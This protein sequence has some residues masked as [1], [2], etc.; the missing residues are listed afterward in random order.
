M[1]HIT[2]SDGQ[3][4]IVCIE[5]GRSNCQAQE[6]KENSTN[7]QHAGH[8]EN[9]IYALAVAF[10]SSAAVTAG[11]TFLPSFHRTRGGGA[12]LRRPSRERTRTTR[13]GRKVQVAIRNMILWLTSPQ[14]ESSRCEW[15]AQDTQYAILMYNLGRTYS[16]GRKSQGEKKLR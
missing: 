15:I 9:S 8:S 10:A 12:R 5:A 6:K 11:L 13:N 2:L 7:A 16:V 14:D 4:Q 3:G 1:M